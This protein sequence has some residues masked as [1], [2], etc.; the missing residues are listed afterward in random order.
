MSY[1]DTPTKLLH[2]GMALTVSVQVL[3]SFFMEPPELGKVHE[4]LELQLFEAHE[5]VGIAAALIVIAHVAY[6]LISSGNAS[7]RTL[8]PWLTGEGCCKLLGELKQVGSWFKQGLP[9][10]DKSH[11]L[12]DGIGAEHREDIIAH[13]FLGQVL[14]IDSR[15]MAGLGLDASILNLFTLTDI[16]GKG[17]HLAVVGFLKPL[18]DDGGVEATGIG[19]NYLGNGG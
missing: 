16:G 10:P 9:H 17:D 4:Q 12:A 15:C 1:Y 13:E 18:Q 11:T 2:K 19:Q 5:W 7:W 14:D 6:S 3:L 8:F